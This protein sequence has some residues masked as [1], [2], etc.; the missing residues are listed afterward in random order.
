LP[1]FLGEHPTKVELFLGHL[2]DLV[3]MVLGVLSWGDSTARGMFPFG[4]PMSALLLT[5]FFIVIHW[6]WTRRRM[7]SPNA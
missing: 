2:T 3:V 5:L 7:V 1:D 4:F 6:F